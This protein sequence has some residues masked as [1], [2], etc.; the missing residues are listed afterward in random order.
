MSI[1]I[2]ESTELPITTGTIQVDTTNGGITIFMKA[3]P[4]HGKDESLT[5]TKVS[6]DNNLVSLFGETSLINGNEI[7]IFGLP[8]YAKV[9]K[10]KVKTL[11]M[12]CDGANWRII[13]EE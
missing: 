6:R 7:V 8:I 5:I 9:K 11:V 1:R 10:G 4:V 13:R 12:K 2:T 3:G